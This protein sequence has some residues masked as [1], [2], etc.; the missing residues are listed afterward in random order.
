MNTDTPPALDPAVFDRVRAA[1]DSS[2]PLA[3]IDRLCDELK[4][5]GDY[6]NLFYA[7]LMRKRVELGVPPFPT[8]PS[9]ELPGNT[10]EAYEET[11]R[12]AGREIG[13]IYL[14]RGDIPKAW[15]FFRMLGEP[16]PVKDALRT[17]APGPDDDPYPVIEVA[18]QHGLLPEKG[19]DLVLD[20]NGVCSAITMV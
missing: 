17:Y 8:G 11:I 4:Q 7:R 19:F 6:Q 13:Q 12:T 9:T 15:A 5:A 10:H 16:D 2:G 14:A 3:A 1:L 20:R 18:W